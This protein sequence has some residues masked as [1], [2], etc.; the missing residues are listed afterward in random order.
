MTRK[1][2]LDYARGVC[3]FC[4]L[5]AHQTNNVAY[6]Y[7][8]NGFFLMLFFFISGYLHKDRS[9]KDSLVNIARSLLIPYFCLSLLSVFIYTGELKLLLSGDIEFIRSTAIRILTGRSLWFVSCLVLVRLIY[10][11]FQ[12]VFEYFDKWNKQ[13]ILAIS[14]LSIFTVF[15]VNEHP[16]DEPPFWYWTTSFYSFG[17]YLLGK[18][19]YKIE[20]EQYLP[21]LK[22][23]WGLSLLVT[24]S[25]ISYFLQ[26]YLDI[27]FHVYTDFFESPA[28]FLVLAVI[29]IIC[30]SIFSISVSNYCIF[31]NKYIVALGQNSLLLFAIN[32]KVRLTLSK[33]YSMAHMPLM[34]EPLYILSMC[35]FEGLIIVAVGYFVNKYIPFIVGKH[36]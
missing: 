5:L 36:K 22:W 1:I 10:I 6:H 20:F 12:K 3:A 32:G 14:I 17:F 19:C 11:I 28:A 27:E 9:I 16:A 31:F 34:S 7:I 30:V 15:L 8:F 24:Y 4:V 18:Y 25:V 33:I 13:I 2:W 23:Y 35:I 26:T 21:I 29:G